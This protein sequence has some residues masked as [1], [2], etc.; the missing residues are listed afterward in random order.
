MLKNFDDLQKMNQSGVDTAMK[1]LGDF[2]KGWQAIAA[3]FNDYTKRSLED[4]TSTFEKLLGAK[5][6][7]QAFEIQSSYAKRAYDEYMHQMTKVGTLYADMAKDAYKP[8]EK[9]MQIGR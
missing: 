7:E 9:A 8:L 2:S 4:G 5:S 3:E 1:L 6:M